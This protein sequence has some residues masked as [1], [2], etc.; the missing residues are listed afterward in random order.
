MCII[1]SE[2]LIVLAKRE[3]IDLMEIFQ[4][5]VSAPKNDPEPNVFEP[6]WLKN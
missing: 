5:A 6:D 3:Q 1:L 2:D 4:I